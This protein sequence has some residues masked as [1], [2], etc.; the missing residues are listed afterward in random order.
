MTLP[1]DTPDDLSSRQQ[2]YAGQGVDEEI[3]AD[4]EDLLAWSAFERSSSV[5][6]SVDGTTK[7]IFSPARVGVSACPVQGRSSLLPS[8]F[9]AGA[10]GASSSS[11]IAQ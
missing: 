6:I 7:P 8:P 11:K 10:H 3:L 9:I 4:L 5:F 1:S 2:K